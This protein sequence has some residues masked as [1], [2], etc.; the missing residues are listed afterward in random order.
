MQ[1]LDAMQIGQRKG[2]PFSLCR[3]DELIDVDRMNR[4][5]ALLVAT[6]VAQR[7]P[8]SGETGQKDVSHDSYP[9]RKMVSDRRLSDGIMHDRHAASREQTLDA[10]TSA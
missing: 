8:A 10:Y 9:S 7:F 6:T 5:S 3:C 1:V 4:F 2:K